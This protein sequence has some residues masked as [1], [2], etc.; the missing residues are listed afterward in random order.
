MLDVDKI[1]A[2]ILADLR[3]RGVGNPADMTPDQAFDQWCEWNGLIAWGPRLRSV[4]EA[5]RAAEFRP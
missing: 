4:M 3:E 5:L 2:D 1:P